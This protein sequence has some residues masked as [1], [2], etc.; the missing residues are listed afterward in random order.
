MN[1]VK[2]WRPNSF[3]LQRRRF[4]HRSKSTS[5]GIE[6]WRRRVKYC[7]SLYSIH[8]PRIVHYKLAFISPLTNVQMVKNTIPRPNM[9]LFILYSLLSNT[10]KINR[11]YRNRSQYP[12]SL[13]KV[14]Y[15]QTRRSTSTLE[16][17]MTREYRRR[18]GRENVSWWFHSYCLRYFM[19]MMV[20]QMKE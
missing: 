5:R 8:I 14:I 13:I 2:K 1:S 16:V 19:K 10:R 9:F 11:K 4:V 15:L 7:Y 6:D 12:S 17:M 20:K 3:P 18:T